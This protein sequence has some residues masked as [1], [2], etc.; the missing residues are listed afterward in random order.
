MKHFVRRDGTRIVAHFMESCEYASDY[1][2]QWHVQCDC[3]ALFSADLQRHA[4][5]QWAAHADEEAVSALWSE[6]EHAD[7]LV[8]DGLDVY[9]SVQ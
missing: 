3:G 9:G 6:E 7:E 1:N 2:G 4:I 5:K 8:V